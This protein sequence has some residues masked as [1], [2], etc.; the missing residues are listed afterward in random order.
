MLASWDMIVSECGRVSGSSRPAA[1]LHFV[2]GFRPRPNIYVCCLLWGA[3]VRVL[4]LVQSPL[5]SCSLFHAISLADDAD[6][7]S[8]H[9]RCLWWFPYQ[10]KHV[11]CCRSTPIQPSE[12]R[13]PAESPSSPRCRPTNQ[14]WSAAKVLFPVLTPSALAVARPKSSV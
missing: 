2:N 5:A 1:V 4:R 3:G 11:L 8:R 13:V 6:P 14:F 7:S 10:G 9:A 12:V